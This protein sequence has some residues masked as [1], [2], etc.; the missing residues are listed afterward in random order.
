M[1]TGWATARERLRT[2]TDASGVEGLVIK[3]LTSKYLPTTRGWTKVRRRDT[4]EA[5]IGA[6]TG[7]VTRPQ[8]L[9]LGRYD[10]EGRLRAVSRTVPLRPEQARLDTVLVRPDVVAE[11]S[12]DRSVD[13]S[14]VFRHPLAPVQANAHGR[15]ARGRPPVRSGLC[16]GGR[17]MR[18]RKDG[19]RGPIL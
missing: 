14:G 15:D 2:R 16:G 12:A 7:T 6:I 13:R 8:L 4:T 17:L 11:I 3:P 1:T 5:I 19:T 9:V 10:E 18:R